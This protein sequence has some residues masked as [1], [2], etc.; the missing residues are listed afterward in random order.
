NIESSPE[1]RCKF[2]AK[3]GE[4]FKISQEY[5]Q[6]PQISQG[7]AKLLKLG[8]AYHHS[9]I[10]QEEK[11]LIEDNFRSGTIHTL[12]CTST[13][14]AGVNL[15]AS[16]VIIR[17]PYTGRSFIT[18][19]G[20][21]QMAGRAGRVGYT[22]QGKSY[23]VL[24]NKSEAENFLNIFN[25]EEELC[26]SSLLEND[27][28]HLTHLVLSLI[29]LTLIKKH[30]EIIEA[31]KITLLKYDINQDNV[32]EDKI[33]L[34]LNRLLEYKLIGQNSVENG[35]KSELEIYAT[36]LGKA[37]QKSH[38]Q[39]QQFPAVYD[40][41]TSSLKHF[42]LMSP[43]HIIYVI[44]AAD[45]MTNLD[46]SKTLSHDEN[47]L[48]EKLGINVAKIISRKAIEDSWK[49]RK[50]FVALI[51]YKYFKSP[52]KISQIE[53]QVSVSIGDIEKLHLAACGFGSSLTKFCSE[54]PNFKPF[55]AVLENFLPQFQVMCFQ[56]VELIPLLEL[57]HISSGRAKLF[58]EKGIDSVQKISNLDG[59]EL[60]RKIQKIN[61]KQAKDI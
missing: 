60:R 9:S 31:V 58:I 3:F 5:S 29:C 50:L 12:C 42:N 46:L 59:P 43:F 8:V 6:N 4:N 45:H 30:N 28:F 61:I 20:Y 54:L 40:E 51:L 10:S 47:D 1:L 2:N 36:N 55:C 7:I 24:N 57:P 11:T 56:N 17:S 37:L 16:R 32:I 15:P 27:C 39:I 49:L 41:L 34:C 22:V 48:V 21:I 13:L 14:A 26:T 53:S 52:A 23:I 25:V 38:I 19:S 44:S 33:M 35:T 18:K